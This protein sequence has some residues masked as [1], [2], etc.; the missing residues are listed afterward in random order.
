MYNLALK[1]S[2]ITSKW[3]LD[4][5]TPIH[6]EESNSNPDNYRGICVMNSLL[7][8]LCL[9]MNKRLDNHCEENK[10]INIGQIGFKKN[11]RTSDHLLTLKTIINKCV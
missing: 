10:I 8:V 1:K 9:L 2:L 5:I 3:C 7:K 4:I 6:K 11:S